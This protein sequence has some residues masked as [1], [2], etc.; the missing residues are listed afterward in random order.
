MILI[1]TEYIIHLRFQWD[2]IG[3]NNEYIHENDDIVFIHENDI[4]F[5]LLLFFTRLSKNLS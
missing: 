4:V 5:F 1:Y 3:R 2:L